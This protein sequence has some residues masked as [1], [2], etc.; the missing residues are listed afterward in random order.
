MYFC[1]I[2]LTHNI[3]NL[4]INI[5]TISLKN[6]IIYMQEYFQIMYKQQ[7]WLETLN[8][9]QI[10]KRIL[11]AKLYFNQLLWFCYGKQFL[12]FSCSNTTSITLTIGDNMIV[13]VR[14]QRNK[15][16]AVWNLRYTYLNLPAAINVMV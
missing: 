7:Y 16:D 14:G 13:R 11:L 3:Y 6:S 12:S 1:S 10:I 4:K 9:S 15:V 2:H 5:N 8:S